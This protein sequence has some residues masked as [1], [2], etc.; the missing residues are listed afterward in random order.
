ML[1]KAIGARLL[2]ALSVVGLLTALVGTAN[3]VNL[4]VGRNVNGNISSQSGQKTYTMRISRAGDYVITVNRRGSSRL[5]PKVTV[6]R[7]STQVGT[8]D[9][10]GEGLN[11]RLEVHLRTGS[12]RVVVDAVGSSRGAFTIR[13][14]RQSGSKQRRLHIF[15]NHGSSRLD[16]AGADEDGKPQIQYGSRVHV[17]RDLVADHRHYRRQ[18]QRLLAGPEGPTDARQHPGRH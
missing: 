12:Y 3:A 2:T 4:A 14:Q 15:G 1:R 10:G 11:S 6:F 17:P 16:P 8:N 18:N 5:D 13:A 7:G 9:D